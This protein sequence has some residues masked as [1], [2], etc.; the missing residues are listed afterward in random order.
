MERAVRLAPRNGQIAACLGYVY[1]TFARY[2]DAIEA[3]RR[4]ILLNF[5]FPAWIAVNLGFAQCVM[6]R[7]NEARQTLLGVVQNQPRYARAYLVLAVVY[8]R[9]GL[10]SDAT[11]AAGEVRRL[12]PLF[13]I[14]AWAQ[15][16][17]YADKTIVEAFMADLQAVGLDL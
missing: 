17:P 13:S 16:R 1:E 7:L 5:H 8:R 12:D 11:R 10:M 9:L 15:D 4:A 6:G 2:D 14:E 3:Y